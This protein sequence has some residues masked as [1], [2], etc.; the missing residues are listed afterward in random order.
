MLTYTT[1]DAT[2]PTGDGNQ[3]IT[4]VCNDIGRWGSGF[5]V[6]LSHRWPEPE[7]VYRLWHTE[8]LDGRSDARFELG[9]T[10]L[11]RVTDNLIVA[12]MIAQRGT[13]KDPD[14][15][16]CIRYGALERCLKYVGDRAHAS[17]SS[18]HM[19]RIGAGLAGGDWD[20]IEGMVIDQICYRGI[21]VTVYDL[22]ED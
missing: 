4:H 16:P 14:G 20:I 9:H 21:P 19:P 2:Q 3:I 1:G 8:H 11:A 10:R 15:R 6:A 17:D 5:V 18:V 13:G 22:K 12:N 7:Q